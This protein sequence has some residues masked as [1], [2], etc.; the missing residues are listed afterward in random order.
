MKNKL[1]LGVIVLAVIVGALLFFGFIPS[2]ASNSEMEIIFYDAEG[3]ELGRTDTRLAILGI[4]ADGFEGDIYSLKIVVYFTV[5]TDIDYIGID[6]RCWLT[7]VTTPNNPYASPVH[8][9]AEHRLGWANTDLEGSFYRTT[10]EGHYLM[11]ELLPA[12]AITESAKAI[13]WNMVFTGRLE[14]SIGRQDGTI[15]TVEDTCGTNLVLSWTEQLEL[16][17]WFGFA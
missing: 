14:T 10:N 2:E 16:D 6:T 4:R 8:T 11:E 5:T 9:V 7:V 12:A 15:A 13:G 17:S 1:V 3:N